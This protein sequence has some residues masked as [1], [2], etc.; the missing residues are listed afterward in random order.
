MASR[1]TYITELEISKVFI[2]LR[3]GKFTNIELCPDKTASA[4]RALDK[5][6]LELGDVTFES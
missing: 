5:R 2:T 6:N 1:N 3:P 4:L